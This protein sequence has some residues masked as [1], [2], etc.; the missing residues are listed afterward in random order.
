MTLWRRIRHALRWRLK[1]IRERLGLANPTAFIPS[2]VI[3]RQQMDFPCGGGTAS[4]ISDYRTPL[5]ETV[6]EV[7]DY[8]C[9]QLRDCDWTDHGRSI[10]VDAGANVGVTAVAFAGLFT[11]RIICLEPVPENLGW[12]RENLARNS[13]DRAEIWPVGVAGTTRRDWLWRDPEQSVSA[14]FN[15]DL[16]PA[17]TA[18]LSGTEAEF[19]TLS[20]ILER[21]GAEDIAL[22]KLDIE[23]A[24]HEVIATLDA[25][26][27]R[28]IRQITFEVHESGAGANMRILCRRLESL[29]YR[30]TRRPERFGRKGLGHLLARQ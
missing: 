10:V 30:L 19:L 1:R 29:G 28:R 6:A 17:F 5:Y 26:V 23:G 16:T 25:S 24:E 27:A 7:M 13:I 2:L 15:A 8:D 18:G 12:L 20:D 3:S 21:A 4:V 22:L 11:G 14:H 9:Y